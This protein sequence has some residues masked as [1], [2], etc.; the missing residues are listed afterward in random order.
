MDIIKI[1]LFTLLSLFLVIVLKGRNKE[2]GVFLSIISCM[3]LLVAFILNM[4]EIWQD[5]SSLF[6]LGG[7]NFLYAEILLKIVGISFLSQ[8]VSNLCCDAGE[9]SLGKSSIL[10]G[11]MSVLILCIPIIKD[12]VEAVKSVLM[13]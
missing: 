6:D 10:L 9:V 5:L 3:A 4:Q 8:V 13:L 12:A 2:F 1:L 7:V 11:K